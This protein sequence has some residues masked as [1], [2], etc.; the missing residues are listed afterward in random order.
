[1]R[2]FLAILFIILSPTLVLAQTQTIGSDDV[3]EAM[4]KA[5]DTASDEEC[6]T[7][8][9]TTGDF[10]WQTCGAG[11]SLFTDGGDVT[12][13][14]S[15]TDD[16]ALGGTDDNATFHFDV[17]TGVFTATSITTTG[18]GQSSASD[19]TVSGTM[20]VPAS[21]GIVVDS[22]GEVAVDTSDGQLVYYSTSKRVINP[23]QTFCINKFDLVAADDDYPIMSFL[24]AATVTD[25]LCLYSGTGSTVA[26]ISLED[27]DGNAMTHT[28]PTCQPHGTPAVPQSI[29]AGGAIAQGELVRFDVDNTPDPTTD[30]YTICIGYTFDAQ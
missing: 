21:T 12:Y 6:L 29:T 22:N 7:Y 23:K 13:L 10:E 3:T 19:L 5:V 20:T 27:D 4:L 24:D 25:V 15:T 14:T 2:Q 26:S 9:T 17:G 16:L 11:S 18:S 8:E 30:D 28:A 1:M